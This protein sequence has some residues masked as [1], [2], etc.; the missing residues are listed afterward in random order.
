MATKYIDFLVTGNPAAA[1]A[2]ATEKIHGATFLRGVL[3]TRPRTLLDLRFAP[4]F[5]FTAVPASSTIRALSQMGVRYV[6]R[7]VP[8]H[9][10]T[11]AKMHHNPVQVAADLLS[12]AYGTFPVQGPVMILV[13]HRSDA[14]AFGP[15]LAQAIERKS[16]GSWTS[17]FV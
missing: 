15:Y 11:T 1:R 14:E 17:R 2:V 4:H 7:S 16:G 5:E 3:E 13:Q 8:F 9:E 12:F 6:Q 10:Q